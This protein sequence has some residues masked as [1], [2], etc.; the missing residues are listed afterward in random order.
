MQV[1]LIRAQLFKTLQGFD[2]RQPP[3]ASDPA[4]H[5]GY[6]TARDSFPT[7]D[8]AP[9]VSTTLEVD[10]ETRL[11]IIHHGCA[12][13]NDV[14]LFLWPTLKSHEQVAVR[15]LVGVMTEGNPP[16][17]QLPDLHICLGRRDDVLHKMVFTDKNADGNE[18][19]I[20]D[21]SVPPPK[22]TSS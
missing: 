17:P 13:V 10:G 21:D 5:F 19:Y 9:P 22:W 4:I 1:Q 3:C 8:D 20:D 18:D 14:E 6:G 16:L 7:V 15:N 2:E 11:Y 12:E